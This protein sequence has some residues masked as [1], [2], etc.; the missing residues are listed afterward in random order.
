MSNFQT[1]QLRKVQFEV[2]CFI[3]STESLTFSIIIILIIIILNFFL[4]ACERQ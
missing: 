2:K 1:K 3:C 4:K